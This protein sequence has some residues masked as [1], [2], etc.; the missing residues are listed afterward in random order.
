MVQVLPPV[1]K[2]LP[3]ARIEM[4][5]M[6]V[7]VYRI[8]RTFGG[9]KLR[10]DGVARSVGTYPDRATALERGRRLAVAANVDVVIH[11]DTGTIRLRP[12]PIRWPVRRSRRSKL[13]K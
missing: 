9:W 3:S 1:R 10:R 8:S 4:S 2:G 5:S 12:D 6:S 11:D 7:G 13:P